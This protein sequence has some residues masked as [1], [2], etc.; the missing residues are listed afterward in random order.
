[1]RMLLAAV[2]KT[3]KNLLYK[4]SPIPESMEFCRA[5]WIETFVEHY[6]LPR[7]ICCFKLAISR[8]MSF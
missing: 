8:S 3:N 2:V 6:H 1:M 5:R 4:Y 7:A